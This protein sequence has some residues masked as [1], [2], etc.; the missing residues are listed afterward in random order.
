ME[1]NEYQGLIITNHCLER[2]KQRGVTYQK[3]WETHTYPDFQDVLR[4]EATERKKKY[5]ERT[6]SILFKRNHQNETIII[7]CWMEPPMPGSKDA[8]QQEWYRRYKK[9]GF[10]GKIWLTAI[11]QIWR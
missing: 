2:M 3:I 10:W 6:V 9:A 4:G 5:G 8:R 11:K 7:S 1:K